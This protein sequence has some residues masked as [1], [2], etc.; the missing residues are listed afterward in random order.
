MINLG[1][2]FKD[3][4]ES[5]ALHALV[6]I[7]TAIDDGIFLSKSGDLVMW[8][9][10]RGADYECLDPDETDQAARRFEAS[11]RLL[12]ERFRLYQYVIKQEV[13][14]L[15]GEHYGDPIVEEASVN[16]RRYL[17]ARSEKLC[18]IDQYLAVVYEGW[19]PAH[20][21]RGRWLR[22]VAHGNDGVGELFT[23]DA[24][25]DRLRRDLDVAKDLLINKVSGFAAQLRDFLQVEVLDTQSA[26]AVLRRLL[27]YAPYKVDGVRLKYNSFVDFQACDSALECHR[28]F[29]RLDD[30][31]VAVLTLKEPP[32]RTSSHLL[33]GATELPANYIICIEWRRESAQKVRRAIQAKRRHFFNSKA[34]LMNYVNTGAQ[35]APRDM[36]IDDGAVAVV[37]NLGASLEEIELE[38]RY[39]GE[40]SLTLI[41]YHQN[42]SAVRRSVA[43]A[44]KAFAAYDAQLTEERYNRLNAW[45]AALPGNAVYNLRRLWLLNTNYADLSF[46]FTLNTGQL[47][48]EHL[49]KEYLAILEGTAGTP[50][51][52]NL[53]CKD[54]G[55]T[56]VL[57]ATGS[58]KS[59]LLNFLL[60]HVQKYEPATYIFDLGGSYENLTRLFNGTYVPIGRQGRPFSINPFSL[61]P[62]KENLLFLFAFVKVLIEAGGYR[63]NAEEERDLYEQIENLYAVAADQRR[64]FTLSNILGRNLRAPL[65]KWVEG[66]PYAFLFDNVED[67][68]TFARFQTFDFEGMD[69]LADQLEPLLFYVLHRAN[70]AIYDEAQGLKVF[71]IDEAW[72]FFRNPVIKNYIMEALK[73]WRK[74][75]AIMILATQSGNDLVNSEMLPVVVES[76]PTKFFLANPGLDREAY[77]RA[78]HLNDT[79]TE[80]IT[81]LI[82]KQQILL[83]QPGLSKRLDL[84]VDQKEYWIYTNNPSDNAKRRAAF[85]RCGFSEGL[86]AL[87]RG[88]A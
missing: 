79:E 58:G 26:F 43:Q 47:R 75:N 72:R 33:R 68:L 20:G 32:A 25:G 78:F 69:K 11:L 88:N 4:R 19:R 2:I 13:A 53:H 36:L 56:V 30:H 38:G 6:G 86:E 23:E 17:A 80:L 74:K 7:Q 12:D 40:F 52:L 14:E 87:A 70:A 50:F 71:V 27:N 63:P 5:G 83:K 22:S 18:R 9:A 15:P 29:L 42:E 28:D 60:T 76:C 31:Y 16:R 57:G 51:F 49:D 46:L 44:F 62:T 1:R 84:N 48:N 8:L 59:F 55:H 10:I 82:P 85:E 73:T 81:R 45:L 54:V 61:A 67:H 35:T 34:S 39:F 64:L 41:L 66:G 21:R 37:A 77:Q 65:Q 24:Y 3:Y